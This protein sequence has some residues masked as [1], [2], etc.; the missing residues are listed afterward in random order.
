MSGATIEVLDGTSDRQDRRCTG[1]FIG[2]D[3]PYL[4]LEGDAVY[5]ADWR[6]DLAFL[7]K[8]F[9]SPRC[10]VRVGGCRDAKVIGR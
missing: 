5:I 9:K 1:V 2:R 3:G 8:V 7:L 6:E 4:H 10:L